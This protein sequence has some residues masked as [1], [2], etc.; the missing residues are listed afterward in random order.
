M[1]YCVFYD[2]EKGYYRLFTSEGVELI[3]I[4]RV[5]VDDNFGNGESGYVDLTV[6]IPL[7]K[8]I[9]EFPSKTKEM[10][11]IDLKICSYIVKETGL[12]KFDGTCEVNSCLYMICGK[13]S[14]MD[15][16]EEMKDYLR[17]A[18]ISPESYEFNVLWP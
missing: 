4:G 2:T 5:I 13:R 3:G 10:K 7:A 18:G 16:Q 12:V 14:I 9:N 11:K 1:D 17:F 6:H 15:V 8:V